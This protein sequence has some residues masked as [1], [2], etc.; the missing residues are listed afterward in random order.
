MGSS[1]SA[2]APA[3]TRVVRR[4][5]RPHAGRPLRRLALG[6]AFRRHAR[7]SPAHGSATSAAAFTRRS[8]GASSPT[9]ITPCSS[10]SRWRTISRTIPR[11]RDRGHVA[12]RDRRDSR[13][14]RSTSSLCVSVLEHLWEP[15]AALRELRRVLP[16]AA[17]VSSTCPHGGESA[18]SSSPR[19]GSVSA[20]PSEMDDHKRYY[21]PRDLWPLLVRGRLRPARHLLPPPQVRPEHVRRVPGGADG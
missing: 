7:A 14:R 9:S 15:L 21:D 13:R 18:S 5:T 19:T 3:R 12:R 17:S 10:M 1:S 2:D 6:Q 20:P 16:P 11:H 8:S 4:S